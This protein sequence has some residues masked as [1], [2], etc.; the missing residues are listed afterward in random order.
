M[1][2]SKTDAP[3]VFEGFV[4][5]LAASNVSAVPADNTTA[6][7]EVHHVRHAPR[8]LA[9]FAGKEV[10]LRMAPGEKLK[11]G[12]K[13]IF[14]TDSLV[15]GDHLA[16]QSMGHDPLVAPEA[17]A[18]VAGVGEVVQGLRRRIDTA[19]SI[20]SGRVVE[21][22]PPTPAAPKVAAAAAAI[23]VMPSGPI[24]EHEPFWQ[25]AVIEVSGV[26]KGPQQ[27]KVIVRFPASTDV[28]WSRAPKFKKGQTGVWLLHADAPPALTAAL[29]TAAPL[30]SGTY[31]SLDPNDFQ[32]ASTGAVVLA[33]LPSPAVPEAIKMT[34]A[35]KATAKRAKPM[36]AAGKKT[37]VKKASVKAKAKPLRS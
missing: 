9:G 36:K 11:Q 6:V 7:V 31:T 10:T 28:Q 26:H 17:Q 1:P 24:S 27:K 12:D 15:F 22:R 33:M 20:V 37:A 5:S 8:S 35:K 4:K 23:P 19:R 25:E 14:F 2:D 30:P 13:A 16:V 29:A 21:V 34:P 3:F 32:P 18:A